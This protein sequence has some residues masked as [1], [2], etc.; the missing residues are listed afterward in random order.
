MF[1]YP[2]LAHT[3]F[4][5]RPLTT[6]LFLG[7]SIHET[8]QVT[9]A[10][11]MYDSQYLAASPTAGEIAVVAKLVRN[12]LMAVAI[13]LISL[14]YVKLYASRE[15]ACRRRSFWQYLPV[16]VLG[17]VVMALVRTLGDATSQDGGLA[18]G[19]WLPETWTQITATTTNWAKNLLG[20][21]M[22]GVGLSTSYKVLK[23]LG[24]RPFLL[25][26]AASVLVGVVSGL[27]IAA[28]TPLLT[29]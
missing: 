29:A 14:A 3:L 26:L 8:A 20:V 22:A 24:I 2:F 11:L 1:L 18:L 25:G 15:E 27:L 4:G 9:G 28:F 17:F 5:G 12:T 21:A 16:F 23:G 13:P 10:A 7:T 19:L 6:G